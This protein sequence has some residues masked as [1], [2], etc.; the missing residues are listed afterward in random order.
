MND[1]GAS[2]R[3]ATLVA[4]C[5]ER[6]KQ[7]VDN[8]DIFDRAARRQGRNRAAP[9]YENANFLRQ[10]MLDGIADRLDSIARR[11]E[12]VLDLGS[13]NGRFMPPIGSRVARI[14]AG[15]RFAATDKGVQADEDR[16]PFADG[17]FDLVVSAG[18]LDSVGDLPGALMLAQR[19]LRPDGLFLAAFAGAGSLAM[20]RSVLQAAESD[21]PAARI[22]PQVDVRSAGDLLMRAGFALPVADTET[23]TV[24]YASLFALLH[25]LRAMAA[26]N[27]MPGRVPL[28]RDVL[29]RAATLFAERADADGRTSETF[30][31]VYMTGWSPAPSQPQPARRGSATQSLAQALKPSG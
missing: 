5:W 6:H 29:A 11:F 25:D 14:D 30:E 16:L 28:R 3:I 22:H 8:P 18:V 13:F 10:F 26:G 9:G 2:R 7:R 19:V 20:L 1:R 12:D 31:I 4:R 24:R 17:S 23:L 21:R 27:V 15:F